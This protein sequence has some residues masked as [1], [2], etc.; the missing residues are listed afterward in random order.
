MRLVAAPTHLH[1]LLAHT[2]TGGYVMD[3]RVGNTQG[4]GGM[5]GAWQRRGEAC[6]CRRLGEA[7]V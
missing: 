2:P 4:L 6:V 5:F 3:R 7:R 1:T